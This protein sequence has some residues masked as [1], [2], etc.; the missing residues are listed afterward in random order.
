V[1]G[2]TRRDGLDF[3]EK[4]SGLLGEVGLVEG[5]D[6]LRAALPDCGEVTLDAAQVQLAVQGGDEEDEVDVG[7]EQLLAGAFAGFLTGELG[8]SLEQLD[9]ARSS[10]GS[11]RASTQSPVA[12]RSSRPAA[13]YIIF[14]GRT[15]DSR[16]PST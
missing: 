8:S 10:P 5:D 16:R 7:G 15:A 6:G 3:G 2:H 1:H 9:T 13:P 11:G 12:G 14:P 4:R